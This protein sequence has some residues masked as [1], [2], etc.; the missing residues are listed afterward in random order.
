MIIF[1]KVSKIYGS[2]K[3]VNGVDFEMKDNQIMGL[4]GPNGAGKT[5]TMRLLCGLLKPDEGRVMVNGLIPSEKKIATN[6]IIGYLPENNPLYPEMTARDYLDFVANLRSDTKS[7]EDVSEKVGLNEMLGKKIESL[8]RGYRQRVG[9]ASAL[10]GNPRILILDEPTSGLDP[11]EQAKIRALIK[12][13]GD[14]RLVI[15]STHIL[16]EAEEIADRLLIINEGVLVFD[17]K[18]PSGKGEVEKLFMKKVLE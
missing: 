8:S 9:L 12:K 18:K 15:L 16:S 3:A 5:T 7:V 14:D 10:L 1:E 4:L 6:N 17:G 2:K 11:I 13:L